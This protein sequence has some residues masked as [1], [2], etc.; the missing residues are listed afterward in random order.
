METGP[1]SG[2]RRHIGTIEAA[3]RR[4]DASPLL[5]GCGR[6][7]ARRVWRPAEGR[8]RSLTGLNSPSSGAAAR[9]GMRQARSRGQR[10]SVALHPHSGCTGCLRAASFD[11]FSALYRIRI[12][13]CNPD[14]LTTAHSLPWM[15]GWAIQDS[16]LGP[17]PYQ[18][19]SGHLAVVS[20]A[21][22]SR[23]WLQIGPSAESE[24]TGTEIESWA[25]DED[26]VV[27][28]RAAAPSGPRVQRSIGRRG[29]LVDAARG[30]QGDIGCEARRQSRSDPK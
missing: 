1:F 21:P 24:P 2:H 10:G 19:R 14:K 23:K 6:L 17:L 30:R 20:V 18:A 4:R 5:S 8:Q 27:R 28:K 15:D 12:K 22:S 25:A 11:E 3:L 16:N 9:R 29:G 13:R 7:S 26:S